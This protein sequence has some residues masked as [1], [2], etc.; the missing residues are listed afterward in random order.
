VE[1][2]EMKKNI[3]IVVLAI[4]L[5]LSVGWNVAITL[6][7]RTVWKTDGYVMNNCPAHYEQIKQIEDACFM[8]KEVNSKQGE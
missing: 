8:G 4:L 1:D 3:A 5:T 2:T 6:S 7:M